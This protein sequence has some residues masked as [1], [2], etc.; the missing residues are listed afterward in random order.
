MT[1]TVVIT[2]T[3]LSLIEKIPGRRTRRKIVD[4]I[5]ALST[6]PEKQGKS[7]VRTLRGF[8]SVHAAGRYRIV[9]KIEGGAVVVYAVAAGI[10]KQGDKKDVYTIVKKLLKAGLLDPEDR[11]G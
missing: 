5:E 8:R 10:R 7:L 3:C 1:C 2:E 4:R 6:D 9:Y 11:D